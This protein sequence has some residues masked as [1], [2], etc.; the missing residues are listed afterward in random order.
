[1]SVLSIIQS[2]CRL[3]A[4]SVPTSVIGS[5]DTGVLQ[6]LEVLT[7]TLE[8]IVTE[9]KFN[10]TTQEAT[11]TTI[12]GEDQGEMTTLAPNG[13]NS[14]IFET[15]YDRT[16]RMSLRGPLTETE[17]QE[18]KALPLTGTPYS[19]RIRLNHLYLMPAPSTPVST[20]AFE[21]MSSWCVKSSVGVLKSG[22]TAD[23]D[24]FVFP[25]NILKRGVAFRWKQIKGL[26][27]QA[28]ETQYYNL[29]NNYIAKDKVKRRIN[30]GIPVRTDF[31][32][33][34]IA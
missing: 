18:V 28:D 11:F 26:P 5:T 34:F 16:Q 14:A 8:E 20:I 2:H 6:L 1:M 31:Q 9:S 19:F 13:Y 22:I 25:D 32:P 23:D 12:A 33:G 24:V 15:F 27:Y 30:V 10:V 29:L 17:W 7:S 4:L 21:Y 3:H